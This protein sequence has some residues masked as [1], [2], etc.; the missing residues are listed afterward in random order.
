MTPLVIAHRG[1][2]GAYPENTVEAFRAARRMGADMVELDV[3][4]TSDGLLAVHHDA[5]LPDGR[6]VVELVAGNLPA[7]V[8]LLP[9]AI[10]ACEGMD[11]NIEVKNFPGDPDFEDSE[12]VATRVT[13]L[14]SAGGLHERV[15]VSSFNLHAVDTVRQVDPGVRTAWLVSRSPD[16]G[17]VLDRLVEHGHSVL[18][19]H[20]LAVTPEL[21]AAAHER[22]VTVNTW[23]VDD[24]ARIVELAEMG[25]DGI[26]TNVPDIA[27]E[28]LDRR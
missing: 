21:V 12:L 5:R 15:L 25:I 28:V 6:L 10:E 13:E 9:A 3:R 23:T 16:F 20:D 27:R 7:S 19:P 18:H 17:E 14:V 26:C 1:A 22:G 4:R 8:A 24:P 11:V 2:S